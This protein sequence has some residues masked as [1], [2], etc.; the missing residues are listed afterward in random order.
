MTVPKLLAPSGDLLSAKAALYAGADEL[1]LGLNQF[2]ARRSAK[3]I[4]RDDLAE[5]VLLAR[6]AHARVFLTLNV[7][8]TEQEFTDAVELLAEA[9][10]LG[11]DG[12]ILQDFG[13]FPIVCRLFPSC[14]IHT[15]TQMT[16]SDILRSELVAALGAARIN[17]ARELSLNEITEITSFCR[18]KGVGTEVFIHGAYCFSFSGQC[19]M[20]SFMGGQSGNRGSCFQPC[21]RAYHLPGCPAFEHL[22]LK[23]NNALEVAQDLAATGTQ[24]LKIEGR[25]KDYFY[26]FE[27]VHAWRLTLDA[28]SAGRPHT[29]HDLSH[30]FNRNFDHGYLSS[31]VGPGMRSGNPYDRSVIIAGKI[32]SYHAD[33]KLVTIDSRG[34]LPPFP[35][36]IIIIGSDK[37]FICHG[38]IDEEYS[39][40]QYFLQIEGKL[41]GRIEAGHVLGIRKGRRERLSLLEA[42][43]TYVPQKKELNI[44]LSGSAG[45]PLKAVFSCSGQYA[46]IESGNILKKAVSS[47]LSLEGVTKQLER[48]GDSIYRLSGIE[49][50]VTGQVFLPVSQLNDMRRRA[51]D[52]LNEKLYISPVPIS[53]DDIHNAIHAYKTTS[54]NSFLPLPELTVIMSWG[55][56]KRMGAQTAKAMRERVGTSI[57]FWV[58]FD[59]EQTDPGTDMIEDVAV[60]PYFDS[61]LPASSLDTAITFLSSFNGSTIVC[62]HPGIGLKA[63]Q[64]GKEVILGPYTN[65]TNSMAVAALSEHISVRGFV[66]SIELNRHQLLQM[67]TASR[68]PALLYAFGIPRLMITAQCLL[69]DAVS[70]EK[71]FM[72]TKCYSHCQG[73]SVFTDTSG[74]AFHAVKSSH[75]YTALYNDETVFTPEA[76]K[77]L[78]HLCHGAVI[79][80]REIERREND[81]CTR[82]IIACVADILLGNST[83]LPDTYPLNRLSISRGHDK[84]GLD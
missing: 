63:S 33:K 36:D 18:E 78:S 70:C 57:H 31:R 11:V 55:Y 20:S 43:N 69:R 30:V 64:A 81:D 17:L 1:Y 48:F 58:V 3:Q 32:L 14:E 40:G 5:V 74:R 61:V 44:Q 45:E 27:T 26:V 16:V 82:D 83:Y 7:L 66:P 50:N 34:K 25:L 2:N 80:A 79:D 42:L 28:L 51:I 67:L 62:D 54:P 10:S 71:P 9:V 76:F 37:R 59:N 77:A 12:V 52:L 39:K 13:L 60:I 41:L 49:W 6:E 29:A 46:E 15:S 23:D 47:P 4:S 68:H 65:L 35:W 75:S 22:S 56:F 8:V 73:S 38:V 19:Y 84:R 53:K 72:D 24:S 21:R